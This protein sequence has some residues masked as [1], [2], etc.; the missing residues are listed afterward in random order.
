M[1][2]VSIYRRISR[3]IILVVN[4]LFSKKK[5][6]IMNNS[7][8]LEI[9]SSRS[10]KVSNEKGNRDFLW[11]NPEVMEQF[12]KWGYDKVGM[13]NNE[14]DLETGTNE[15]SDKHVN[16]VT[17]SFSESLYF[18]YM[19]LTG[20]LMGSPLSHKVSY[21]YFAN[22]H[23]VLLELCVRGLY[24][25]EGVEPV[26]GRTPSQCAFVVLIRD[27]II[28]PFIDMLGTMHH[29]G[30]DIHARRI[31]GGKVVQQH[32]KTNDYRTMGLFKID[33]SLLCERFD[34]RGG[35]TSFHPPQMVETNFSLW[36]VKIWNQ[37]INEYVYV[38]DMLLHLWIKYNSMYGL[39]NYDMLSMWGF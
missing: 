5:V 25:L 17:D 28:D 16:R 32:S 27:D 8:G 31:K 18:L 39:A 38:E 3:Q 19:F 36:H 15:W 10:L 7:K 1:V 33:T 34:F 30:I 13:L 6:N 12:D 20:H 9:V 37:S 4:A 22:M 11:L 29:H 26:I 23:N 2:L 21:G 24:V 14:F 35:I